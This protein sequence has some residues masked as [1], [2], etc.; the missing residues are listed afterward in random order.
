V[1]TAFER[2]A[3]ENKSVLFPIRLDDAVK[4]TGNAWAADIRRTRHIGDF[5]RWKDHDWFQRG[6]KRLLRD[7][8]IGC[9]GSRAMNS[10]AV[11]A[12]DLNEHV[13]LRFIRVVIDKAS[14]SAHT[15]QWCRVCNWGTQL[16][17]D[18]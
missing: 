8:E 15:K 17:S 16:S 1:E 2:E 9:R 7:F 12:S 11:A 10:E 3:R 13:V 4:E 14:N 18:P 5:P 6:L